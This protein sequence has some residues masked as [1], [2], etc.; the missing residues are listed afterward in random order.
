MVEECCVFMIDTF[1]PLTETDTKD[2]LKESYNL[3]LAF[4]SMSP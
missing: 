3:F 4:D 1:Q 2:L